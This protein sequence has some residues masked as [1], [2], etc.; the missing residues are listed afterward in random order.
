M[1]ASRISSDA[2]RHAFSR[3]SRVTSLVFHSFTP[4]PSLAE[5][6][7]KR[8]TRLST[9]K[10]HAQAPTTFKESDSNV[11]IDNT[12][13][14]QICSTSRHEHRLTPARGAYHGGSGRPSGTTTSKTPTA[15]HVGPGTPCRTLT[16]ART[17]SP[18]PTPTLLPR[19]FYI[20]RP[21]PV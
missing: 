3:R 19:L 20:F 5:W 7:I 15:R 9:L 4:V 13:I 16:T 11:A 10:T 21:P 17:S 8:Q 6:I 18:R 14:S 12:T 1:L 2:R